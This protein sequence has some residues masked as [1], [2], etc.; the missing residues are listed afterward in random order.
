MCN[1]SPVSKR[2]F[3]YTYSI[4][5]MAKWRTLWLTKVFLKANLISGIDLIKKL[6]DFDSKIRNADWIIT[7]EGNLD[8]Q[9]LSGKTIQGVIASSKK[10]NIPVA[11]FCGSIT[12]TQNE[13]DKAGI[14]YS[15]SIM[16][17]AES[18]EDAMANSSDYLKKI[19]SEFI[20]KIY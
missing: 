4:N 1:K 17:K 9:T 11:A 19:S 8:H 6:V 15:S 10:Y 20:K 18:L 16:E 13:L 5:I 14:L 7:G 2:G 12:L 3:Y